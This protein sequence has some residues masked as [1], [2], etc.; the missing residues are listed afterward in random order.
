[1][2]S[3]LLDDSREHRKAKGAN[4][5]VTAAISHSEYQDHLLNNKNLRHLMNRI[6]SKNHKIGTYEINAI[7]LSLF[8]D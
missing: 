6:N 5:N 4:R 1:M 8:D 3:F 7:S 2:R